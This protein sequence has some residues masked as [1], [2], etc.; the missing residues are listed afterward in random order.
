MKKI[1][2]GI[3]ILL[4]SVIVNCQTEKGYNISITVKGLSEST[5]YLAYHLGNRQYIKDSVKLD[6]GGSSFFKGENKLDQGVYM[7]VLPGNKY[8]EFLMTDDQYF[9]ISCETSDL[10][11]SL[12]FAGSQENSSF[13][14]Y[15]RNLASRYKKSDELKGRLEATKQNPDSVKAL[16]TMGRD[17][18]ASTRSYMKEITEANKGSF[19]AALILAMQPVEIPEFNI[20]ASASNKDSIQWVLGYNY[21]KNHFFDNFNLSDERL[22]RSPL[23]HNKLSYYFN[24]ILLQLPDS[25]I[26]G[27]DKVLTLSSRTKMT[28][29]YTSV[30]LF[31]N[32]RESAIMGHDAVMIKIA[33]EVYLSGRAEWASQEFVDNLRRDVDKLRPS[34]ISN[35]AINLTMETL[36][37]GTV[38]INGIKKEFTILYFWEPDCG[39][40]V[41]ATPLLRD[42][43]LKNSSNVEVLAICTQTDREKWQK[44]IKENKLTWI[45]GWDP[46]RVTHYDF[47]YNVV[48]TPTVFILDRN[49]KIIAKKLPIE[50]I[51]GFIES[52]RKYGR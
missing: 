20:P 9:G 28:Y 49:K 29:Q 8:F 15:Q 17:L 10:A 25:I 33:D 7:I 27:V 44:Y 36:E 11:G 2:F 13:A 34:L 4:L 50:S 3:A 52:Y 37:H 35:Q 38:S 22:L 5:V 19:M 32:F 30:F 26:K 23:Y 16:T 45:N 48:S 39:H 6:M 24:D 41:E 43:Y 12:R 51:E 31:N 47:F 14:E 18:E 46:D 21:N 42:Y 40:C 1:I